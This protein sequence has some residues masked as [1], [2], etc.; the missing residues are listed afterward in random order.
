MLLPY[1]AT[2]LLRYHAYYAT[3]LLRYYATA[4]DLVKKQ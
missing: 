3:T 2:T 1:Y 4:L